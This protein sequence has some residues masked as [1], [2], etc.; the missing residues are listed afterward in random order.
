MCRL[1]GAGCGLRWMCG[2]DGAGR[3][4][5]CGRVDG[6]SGRADCVEVFWVNKLCPDSAKKKIHT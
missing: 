4:V 6:A 1:D 3:C 5:D 2:A